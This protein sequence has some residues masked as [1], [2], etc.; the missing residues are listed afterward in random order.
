[1]NAK[2]RPAADRPTVVIVDDDAE[3]L[4]ALR[5][6]LELDGLAVVTHLSG[7]SLVPA[8][9]P[10]DNGCLVLDFRL[11]TV[12]GLELLDQLRRS[13]VTLPAILITSHASQVVRDR[14]RA[15]GAVL[16]EKPL[17]GDAL[18][19]AIRNALDAR[20]AGHA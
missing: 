10:R 11:P 9:L 5:F 16:V 3:L 2:T 4:R 15:A 1:M 18:L 14:A 17:L 13:D 7:E 12:D 20:R 8:T 19:S 6:S